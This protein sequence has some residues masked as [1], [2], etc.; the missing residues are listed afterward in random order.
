M[1]WLT[2]LL[3][4]PWK[5]K[6]KKDIPKRME[7]IRHFSDVLFEKKEKSK[8]ILL[9]LQGLEFFNGLLSLLAREQI[10]HAFYVRDV[11]IEC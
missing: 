4:H 3:P 5:H 10:I 7:L 2:D 8:S 1:L 11:F 6:A 9:F